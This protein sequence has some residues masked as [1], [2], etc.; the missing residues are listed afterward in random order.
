MVPI[1]ATY[2]VIHFCEPFQLTW[3]SVEKAKGS[4]TTYFF[5]NPISY[6]RQ[7]VLSLRL[8]Y[9]HGLTLITPCI[10]NH[11]TRK[12]QDELTYPFPKFNRCLVKVSNMVSILLFSLTHWG[13]VTHI[14]VSKL[15][16]IGSDNGLSPDRRKAII[17]TNA[18][19]LSIRTL[20]I[21]FQ[22]NIKRICI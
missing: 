2:L 18:G 7:D 6:G 12:V 22:W 11:R 10:I 8:V 9:W 4:K 17:W 1:L 14:C 3:L 5:I 13:Q 20:G 16:I 19:I 21:K 15:T